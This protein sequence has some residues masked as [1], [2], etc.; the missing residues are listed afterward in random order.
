MD[1]LIQETIRRKFANCTMIT[2]AH[3]LHSVIDSDRILVLDNGHLKEFD[4]PHKLLQN[5]EGL[6][7]TMVEHTGKASRDKLHQIATEVFYTATSK[8]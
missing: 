5:P 4:H 7:T 3:R 6:F 1:Q 8:F 2:I